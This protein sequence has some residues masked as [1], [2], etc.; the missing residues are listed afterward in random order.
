MI[1]KDDDTSYIK[2]QEIYSKEDNS[3]TDA[4]PS[5]TN[6]RTDATPAKSFVPRE[7]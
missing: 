3:D 1:K 4:D 2:V 6:D 5:S 7:R